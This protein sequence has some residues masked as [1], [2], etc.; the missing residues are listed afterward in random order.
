LVP[1]L[2]TF[3][4]VSKTL[5]SMRMKSFGNARIAKLVVIRERAAETR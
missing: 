5:Y 1:K 4:A 2:L 3:S